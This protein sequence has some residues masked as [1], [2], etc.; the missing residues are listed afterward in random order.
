MTLKEAFRYCNFLDE[1]LSTVGTFF[2][3]SSNYLNIEEEHLRNKANPAAENEVVPSAYERRLN[4]KPEEIVA[5]S[6][7]VIDEYELVSKAIAWAKRL[8]LGEDD[9][10]TALAVNKR[11]RN[12][13]AYL[14]NMKRVQSKER[15]KQGRAFMINAEGNQVPYTYDIIEKSSP[16]FD[17]SNIKRIAKELSAES[18]NISDRVDVLMVRDSV[19]FANQFFDINDTLEDCIEK[20]LDSVAEAAE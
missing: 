11:R 19:D 6:L 10:D 1:L 3:S 18:D 16:D 13:I 14:N 5:F 8:W 12:I 17:V 9:I 4:Y 7:K 2:L 20:F 15:I